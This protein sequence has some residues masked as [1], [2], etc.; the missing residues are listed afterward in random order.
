MAQVGFEEDSNGYD[1]SA[2]D[3]DEEEGEDEEYEVPLNAGFTNV[4]MPVPL[5]APGFSGGGFTQTNFGGP[6]AQPPPTT[7]F[8][9][10]QPMAQPPTATIAPPPQPQFQQ[11][12]QQPVVGED[13]PYVTVNVKG[14]KPSNESK[15]LMCQFLLPDGERI[16]V[17]L[18]VTAGNVPSSIVHTQFQSEGRSEA[19]RNQKHL[20]HMHNAKNLKAEN[21][22]PN[23][24][25]MLPVLSNGISETGVC[26]Q[27]VYGVKGETIEV[28]LG[29][30]KCD[31]DS[32]RARSMVSAAAAPTSGGFT[33][34]PAGAAVQP[35]QTVPAGPPGGFTVAPGQKQFN[36]EVIGP[37][38]PGTVQHM[39][40]NFDPVTGNKDAWK[41]AWQ[42]PGGPRPIAVGSGWY[43]FQFPDGRVLKSRNRYVGLGD[44]TLFNARHGAKQLEKIADIQKY[45]VK[46]YGPNF[47]QVSGP[48]A[49]TGAAPPVSSG[50]RKAGAKAG[51]LLAPAVNVMAGFAQPTAQPGV[52]GP[53]APPVNPFAPPT[54]QPFQQPAQTGF[55]QATVPQ[56]GGQ[57]P[58]FTG[59]PNPFGGF[60]QQTAQ[61]P[62]ATLPFGQFPPVQQPAQTVGFGGLTTGGGT[63]LMNT[64]GK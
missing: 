9:P 6:M 7:G 13:L 14:L 43:W 27:K 62:A 34:F 10:F 20:I 47:A 59:Q 18:F 2:E 54:A 5:T 46:T 48:A 15:I 64:F 19:D 38:P 16:T 12:V 4:P 31:P 39:V 63:S 26:A 41:P 29:D 42:I 57:L 8:P 3:Y 25:P 50:R 36:E 1:S 32:N 51:T 30:F 23:G 35:M 55:G 28:K 60:V 45:M 24:S 61:A 22:K 52:G 53:F 21:E 49:T 37:E 56:T 33:T 11:P 17:S 44:T 58:I 40:L